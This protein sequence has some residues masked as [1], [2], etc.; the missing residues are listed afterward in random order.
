MSH[1]KVDLSKVTVEEYLEFH[2][3]LLAGDS[4]SAVVELAEKA[5]DGGIKDRSMTELPAILSQMTKVLQEEAD[6]ISIAIT[7]MQTYLKEK[8]DD[9]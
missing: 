3:S 5:I 7:S 6:N 1:I 9:E 2:L 4:F 8:D